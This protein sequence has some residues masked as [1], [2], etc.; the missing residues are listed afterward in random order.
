MYGFLPISPQLSPER[1]RSPTRNLSFCDGLGPMILPLAL[2]MS[3]SP[4]VTHDVCMYTSAHVHT[5]THHVPLQPPHAVSYSQALSMA[6]LYFGL[7][8]SHYV[9][10]LV[11]NFWVPASPLPGPSSMQ[12]CMAFFFGPCR[13]SM[14]FWCLESMT[15]RR[16]S[17]S[18]LSPS[19]ISRLQP[20]K[21]LVKEP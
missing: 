5:H 13:T 1:V 12:F 14:Q 20:R 2:Q 17:V 4:S 7:K 19:T 6:T 3:C 8:E 15:F 11:F 18:C 10:S 16:T 21:I 9:P